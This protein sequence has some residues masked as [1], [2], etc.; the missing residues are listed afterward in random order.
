MS[1]R[2]EPVTSSVSL[3]RVPFSGIWTGV[4]LVHDAS[5]NYL[6][7]SGV[8]AELVDEVI[9]PAL[10]ASGLTVSEL[11]ALL[12]THCH[13]DH[14]GGHARLVELGVREV[15]AARTQVEKLAEPLVYSRRIRAAFPEDSPA[16]PAVLAG[17]KATRIL[18]DGERIGPLQ[19]VFTPGHDSECV[20]FWETRTRALLTGDS[21]QGDGTDTQ[22][23]ALVM[24]WEEYRRSLARMASL[25]PEVIV[26]G[27]DFHPFDR[28]APVTA[29]ASQAAIASSLRSLSE[30]EAAVREQ[31]A[32]G[33]EEIHALAR[34]VV[35]RAGGQLP[36]KLF[37]PL[38][39]TA[40]A[41]AAVRRQ[42]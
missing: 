35:A 37:L 16:P 38:H 21:L 33:C 32:A 42:G 17:V 1:C 7:D 24:Y 19:V 20:S 40:Q 39:T 13:G 10:S 3:L 6:I 29:E 30:Y 23:C 15:V 28:Q 36:E 34:A 11:T 41:L 12:C 8:S 4:Y 22:G 31:L 26:A 14:I 2:F 5:G 25:S 27:H 9:V 18:E